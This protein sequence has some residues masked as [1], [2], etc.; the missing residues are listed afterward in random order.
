[1]RVLLHG[2]QKNHY[3]YDGLVENIGLN[4]VTSYLPPVI[5]DKYHDEAD[6]TDSNS[7][8][9][10]LGSFDLMIF[11]P[12]SFYDSGFR[13]FLESSTSAPKVFLDL[14]DDFFIRNIY[15]NNHISLYFKRELL[16]E[17]IGTIYW[18]KWYARFL[19]GSL[20]LPPIHRKIGLPDDIMDS[21]PFKTAVASRKN[22]KL[23]PFPLTVRASKKEL[24]IEN[25]ER[26]L[27]LFF[28]MTINTI[29]ERRRYLNSLTSY[30][31]DKNKVESIVR[32]GGMPKKE[33]AYTMLRSKSSV[34]VR[35]MGFDTDRYWETAQ[36]GST[37]LSQ[38]IPLEIEHNFIDEE[39]A[40]FFGN[41]EELV[42]KFEK[43]VLAS[44][45]WAEISRNGQ[46]HFQRYHTPSARIRN[47]LLDK[48]DQ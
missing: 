37:L 16:S 43:Y 25:V 45:E 7:L 20:L 21:L 13:N 46:E 11:T 22:G 19:Y 29:S 35:G 26:D 40:L 10:E 15:K 23:R 8:I 30:L 48:L 42:S 47:S 14:E 12:R 28:C 18:G 24:K 5:A 2:W 4:N 34:S 36:Y 44:D 38:R 27:D 31:K 33:Y 39:S 6:T 9:S 41:F 1:M 32:P 17:S 3:L